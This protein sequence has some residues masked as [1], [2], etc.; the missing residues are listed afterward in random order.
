MNRRNFLATLSLAS[1]AIALPAL[2]LPALALR[3]DRIVT[4]GDPNAP[5]IHLV[6]NG[7]Q[8]GLCYWA[9]LDTREYRR[10]ALW[11]D[12]ADK[13]YDGGRIVRHPSQMGM[14][15][16]THH[17]SNAGH[18]DYIP[19]DWSYPVGHHPVVDYE[20]VTTNLCSQ[21]LTPLSV[22]GIA[23]E[24]QISTHTPAHILA[25]Y[26]DLPRYDPTSSRSPA[27]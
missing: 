16:I 22:E 1:T 25:Q 9:N 13:P 19:K 18:W 15:E 4:K 6:K 11:M 5:Y 17:D 24:I 3:Q 14:L 8:V 26:P 12:F 21:R 20:G 27:V 7:K 23:D 10:V 2:A